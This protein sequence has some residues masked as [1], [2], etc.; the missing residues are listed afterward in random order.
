MHRLRCAPFR[1]G[2]AAV[3]NRLGDSRPAPHLG[4]RE[5]RGGGEEQEA[6]QGKVRYGLVAAAAAAASHSP[7]SVWSLPILFP[8]F[9]LSRFQSPSRLSL[10]SLLIP[11][12]FSHPK[13]FRAATPNLLA[14]WCTTTITYAACCVPVRCAIACLFP[15]A[16]PKKTKTSGRRTLR[17]AA[18]QFAQLLRCRSA[19][20][21]Y[22]RTAHGGRPLLVVCQSNPRSRAPPDS[23]VQFPERPISPRCCCCWRASPDPVLPRGLQTSRP[24]G[25]QHHRRR[26]PRRRKLEQRPSRN[27]HFTTG[28][29]GGK[30]TAGSVSRE[31]SVASV[32]I[33]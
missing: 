2:A 14:W 11:I 24:E 19:P 33:D 12:A 8:S 9:F 10:F 17:C 6:R 13:D 1:L 31:G 4:G 26:V 29:G 22:S 25:D 28:A 5:Q 15:A 32:S 27:W 21:P 7:A 20:H 30:L 18:P 16:T 23:S 3:W